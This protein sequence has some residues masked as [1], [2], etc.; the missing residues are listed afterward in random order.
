MHRCH[1]RD[2]LSVGLIV[3]KDSSQHLN[4]VQQR[5]PAV[6]NGSALTSRHQM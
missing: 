2:L 5:T 4:G 1:V 3:R 6:P